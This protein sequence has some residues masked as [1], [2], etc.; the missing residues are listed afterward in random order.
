MES[1]QSY[2]IDFE[3]VLERINNLEEVVSKLISPE[4]MYKRPNSEEYEKLNETLDYLHTE[5]E[6]LK[7]S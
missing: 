1:D 6:K 4:L 2:I 5:V 7:K 3:E